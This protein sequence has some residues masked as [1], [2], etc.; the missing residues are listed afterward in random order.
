MGQETNF[1][2]SKAS[3]TILPIW[4][5]IWNW[6]VFGLWLVLVSHPACTR[7]PLSCT[8]CNL[9]VTS[10]FFFKCLTSSQDR[11]SPVISTQWRG[12]G[13]WMTWCCGLVR[14]GGEFTLSQ[15][16]SVPYVKYKAVFT[17][18]KSIRQKSDYLLLKLSWFQR[19]SVTQWF[20]YKTA[21]RCMTAF[22]HSPKQP[23]KKNDFLVIVVILFSELYSV[24]TESSTNPKRA[25]RWR[26]PFSPFGCFHPWIWRRN[27]EGQ[28]QPH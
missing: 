9:G 7:R 19:L 4:V 17:G 21:K 10:F 15:K 28:R 8:T 20:A 3:V 24:W 13:S 18:G 5:V 23:R 12:Q 2:N 1:Q 6:T 22:Q 11:I 25:S 26:T 27:P 16:L 14:S